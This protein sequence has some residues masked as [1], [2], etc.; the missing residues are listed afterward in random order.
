MAQASL[1]QPAIKFVL[2]Y[3]PEKRENIEIELAKK[4]A[5]GKLVEGGIFLTS[6]FNRFAYIRSEGDTEIPLR[7]QFP[8]L[9][10]QDKDLGTKR[11]ETRTIYFVKDSRGVDARLF[12]RV[13]AG[14]C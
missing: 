11:R 1:Q 14:K 3:G 13:I 12:V 5:T 4:L 7:D 9:K 2:P 10:S 6:T 8:L